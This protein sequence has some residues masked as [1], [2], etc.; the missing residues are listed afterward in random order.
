MRAHRFALAPRW[1]RAPWLAGLIALACANACAAERPRAPQRESPSQQSHAA[2]KPA[3]FVPPDERGFGRAGE[4]IYLEEIVGHALSGKALP[5]LVLIHGR[6]DRP[7]RGW[8]PIAAH[9]PVRVIMPQAPEPF[10]D[11][12][13]WSNV[14]AI[15]ARGPAGAALATQLGQ[16]ADQIAAAVEILRAQRP[17]RGTPLAAGFSQGGML[18]FTLA[19]RHPS[20]FAAL[21]PMAGMLP[22]ALWPRHAPAAPAPPV[23]ALHGTADEVVSIEGARDAIT[24]LA[25]T[26]YSAQLEEYQ[27]VGHSLTPAMIAAFNGWLRAEL[28]R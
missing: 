19:A 23:R 11:G 28:A 26:G 24:H 5:M 15:E 22:E 13:S 4:L 21:M 3:S 20:A 9:K 7:A 2:L 17:T 18:S 25:R 10:G 14:R 12:F 27:G 1:A 8:L 16:R 6:G